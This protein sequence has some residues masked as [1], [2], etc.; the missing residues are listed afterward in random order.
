[1][2]SPSKRR[3]RKK[4]LRQDELL[5]LVNNWLRLAGV[6][7]DE[8]RASIS[9]DLTDALDA[10]EHV[11]RRL[12]ELLALNP[13]QPK[14]ADQALTIAGEISVYLFAELQDHL[15]SLERGWERLLKRLAKLST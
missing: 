9:V 10:A 14:Q 8:E 7:D 1:M 4:P 6:L 2:N 3:L 12:R 11:S 13:S 15:S 5:P